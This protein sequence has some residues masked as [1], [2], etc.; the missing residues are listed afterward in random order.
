MLEVNGH[1]HFLIQ[2]EK[3]L[4][5]EKF[6]FL[7]VNIKYSGT[8]VKKKAFKIFKTRIEFLF[9]FEKSNIIYFNEFK[10]YPFSMLTYKTNRKLFLW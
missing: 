6:A 7:K 9:N 10:H 2:I 5:R 1:T 3:H 8:F 4:E